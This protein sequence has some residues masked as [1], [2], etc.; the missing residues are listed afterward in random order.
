MIRMSVWAAT[1]LAR[2]WSGTRITVSVFHSFA[3]ASTTCAAFELVQVMWHS[4]F[5]SA[6]VFT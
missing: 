4:A 1:F 3:I 5:T 2:Y 6:V